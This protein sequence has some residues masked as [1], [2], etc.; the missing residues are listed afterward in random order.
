VCGRCRMRELPVE[1]SAPDLWSTVHPPARP[2]LPVSSL[3]WINTD[4]KSRMCVMLV[5]CKAGEVQCTLQARAGSGD[6]NS[7]PPPEVVPGSRHAAGLTCG[8]LAPVVTTRARCNPLP[9]GTACTHRVPAG[10]VPSGRG[11]LWRSGP[12]RPGTD[13][14]AGRSKADLSSR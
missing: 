11:R 9:A 1:S 3:E 6:S 8:S 10:S 13:R 4:A 14:P 5:S 12:P 7:G 2:P